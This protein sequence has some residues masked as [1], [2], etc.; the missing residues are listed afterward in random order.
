MTSSDWIDVD[1]G[2]EGVELRLKA[3]CDLELSALDA[4]SGEPVPCTFSLVSHQADSRIGAGGTQPTAALGGLAPGRY[5]AL[6]RAN[7]GRIGCV[8]LELVA[9]ERLKAAIPIGPGGNVRVKYGGESPPL[10]VTLEHHGARVDFTYVSPERS[11]VLEAP[12]GSYSLHLS[13]HEYDSVTQTRR[14]RR[15]ETRAVEITSGGEVVIDCSL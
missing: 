1:A 4:L 10:Y 13:V 8:Q 5:C 6:A 14:T 2:T 15:Q 11:E 9:G 3:G 12:V 7:D